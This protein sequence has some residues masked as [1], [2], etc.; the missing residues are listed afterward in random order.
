M[1]SYFDGDLDDPN[2]LKAHN[3]ALQRAPNQEQV[4]SVNGILTDQYQAQENA[5][6]IAKSLQMPDQAVLLINNYESSWR[7]IPRALVEQLGCSDIRSLCLAD[8]VN[9]NDGGKAIAFSNGSVV[10]SGAAPYMNSSARAHFEY[11]GLNPQRYIGKNEFGF[12]S[13][14]NAR[15]QWDVVSLLFSTNYFK[16]WDK[17]LKSD[18]YFFN[19][20][21]N[22]SF[23]KNY[24]LLMQ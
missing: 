10:I 19:V 24:P 6:Q 12:H 9:Y 5:S 11:T 18:D 17:T 20:L 2:F 21:G 14:T 23:S 15:N 22:H 8:I 4:M 3:Q 13:V 7:D 1:L 16:K